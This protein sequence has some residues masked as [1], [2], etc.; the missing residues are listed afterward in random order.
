MFTKCLSLDN[1]PIFL[2]FLLRND[3][4]VFQFRFLSVLTLGYFI[5]SSY[6]RNNLSLI[7]MLRMILKREYI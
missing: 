1:A 5:L 2:I 3:T 4:R 6:L 7:A